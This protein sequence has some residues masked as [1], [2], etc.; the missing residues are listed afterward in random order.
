MKRIGTLTCVLLL[1][2]CTATG[3]LAGGDAAT[4][5]ETVLTPTFFV[6]KMVEIELHGKRYSGA[7]TTVPGQDRDRW[8]PFGNGLRHH[9]AHMREAQATLQAVDGAR[10]TCRWVIHHEEVKGTCVDGRDRRYR[11]QTL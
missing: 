1:G 10:L 2:G 7:W 8:K 5:D 4:A 11:L 9:V 3:P 6:S